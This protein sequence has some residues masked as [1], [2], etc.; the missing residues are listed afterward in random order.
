MLLQ[1][2]IVT[3]Y[4]LEILPTLDYAPISKSWYQCVGVMSEICPD[5]LAI[6]LTKYCLVL[7]IIMSPVLEPM[8]STCMSNLASQMQLAILTTN[9][10]SGHV[11]F[12]L[13]NQQ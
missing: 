8:W 12:I 13:H 4:V 10:R 9:R 7:D 6:I 2:C 1:Y 11:A 5:T 3:T